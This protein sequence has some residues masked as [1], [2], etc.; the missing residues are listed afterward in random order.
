MRRGRCCRGPLFQVS[1]KHS[2]APISLPVPGCCAWMLFWVY[3]SLHLGSGDPGCRT[4]RHHGRNLFRPIC[5]GGVYWGWIQGGGTAFESLTPWL[6]AFPDFT[7]YL[8]LLSHVVTRPHAFFQGF[9][10]LRW[11]RFARVILTL[12]IAIIPTL[13]VAVFQDVEH[14]PGMNDFLNVLRA[15]R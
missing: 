4:E 8:S 6:T 10:N 2:Q 1:S 7:K 14:L 3:G 13:L 5:Y 12:S 11:S 15:Y 9:L